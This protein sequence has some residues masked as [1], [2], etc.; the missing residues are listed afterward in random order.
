MSTFIN[1]L[2]ERTHTH[3]VRSRHASPTTCATMTNDIEARFQAR[4]DGK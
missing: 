4:E 1:E 3:L 2:D